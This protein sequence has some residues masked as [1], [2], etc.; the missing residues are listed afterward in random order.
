MI[1]SY[2]KILLENMVLV[3]YNILV[4]DCPIIYLIVSQ[5]LAWKF[6]SNF[7]LLYVML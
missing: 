7:F 5:L 1:F 6:A 3:V 4:Y 2:V